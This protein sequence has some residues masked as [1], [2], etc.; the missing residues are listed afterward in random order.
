MGVLRRRCTPSAL[1]LSVLLGV[2]GE[3]SALETDQFYAWTRPLEDSGDPLNAKINAEF[4]AALAQVNA[5]DAGRGF[6][7]KDVVSEIKSRYVLFIFQK[8]E[9]WAARTSLLHRIPSTPDEEFNYRKHWIYR[10]I[11][12]FDLGRTVPPSP[13]IEVAGVRFGTDKLSHF[14]SEGYWYYRWYEGARADGRSRAEAEEVAVKRGIALETTVLGGFLSGVLSM[15]D[16]EA[17]YQGLRFYT[18]LC[19]GDQPGLVKKASGWALREPFD[20]RPYVSPEWDE[21]Y[22][23][24]VVTPGRWVRVKPAVVEHCPTL[25]DPAVVARRAAYAA[26][27]SE[28]FSERV[29]QQLVDEGKIPD[30]ADFGVDRV[31]ADI[32]PNVAAGPAGSSK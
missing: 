31:C 10:D 8:I 3:A 27:D 5:D 2:A 18:G 14:F 13:T 24:N 21:S 7:C 4:D 23:P 16:L 17:N 19:E 20:L 30:P 32:I 29:V 9:L 28:T 11:A 12:W 6:E 1:V 15:G 25:T 22:A 26:R